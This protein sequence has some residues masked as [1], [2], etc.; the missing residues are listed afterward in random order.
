MSKK[1]ALLVEGG[2]MRGAFTAGV[3]TAFKEY[4]LEFPYIIGISAGANLAS[5]YL[6]NQCERN[7]RIYTKWVADKRFLNLSN[8][9]KEGSYFG[10]DF[11]YNEL[12]YKLDP[13]DFE[14]FYK[15]NTCF[16]VGVTHCRTGKTFYMLPA[17]ARSEEETFL[18]L[19]ASSS[20]PSVSKPVLIR[21]QYYLDGA[22]VNGIPIDKSIED[23]NTHHIFISTRNRGYRKAYSKSAHILAQRTLRA[24]PELINGMAHRHIHYNNSLKLLEE[25]EKEGKAFIIAPPHPLELDR[26]EKNVDKL[27]LLYE[28]GYKAATACMPQLIEFMK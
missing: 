5:D 1:L 8:F 13:F 18:M 14:T 19:R 12:G 26:F 24:Y 7:K 28:D 6:S 27:K 3:F 23:G 11:L 17:K 10:L 21:G 16:K 2:G 22:S 20:I 25:L 15:T 4:H 9:L